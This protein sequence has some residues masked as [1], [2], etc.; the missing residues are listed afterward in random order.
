MNS[1]VVIVIAVAATSL[2]ASVVAH[3]AQ[4]PTVANWLSWPALVVAGWAFFGHLI[5]LDDDM[6]GG[7]SNPE[8]SRAVW[9]R[10][11]TELF[12]KLL[13][14]AAVGWWFALIRE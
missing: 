11:V 12:A 13:V 10:S 1:F 14:F 8:G 5:A 4:A 9:R 6:R 2:L 3:L 7:W